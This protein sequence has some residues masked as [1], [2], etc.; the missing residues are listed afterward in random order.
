MN[1]AG[2]TR[3]RD[4]VFSGTDNK[5]RE[6]SVSERY[7]EQQVQTRGME[8]VSIASSGK[9]PVH[10]Y[11]MQFGTQQGMHVQGYSWIL[12]IID[13]HYSPYQWLHSIL[14]HIPGIIPF[15]RTPNSLHSNRCIFAKNLWTTLHYRPFHSIRAH[16]RF[17]ASL[18]R[19]GQCRSMTFFS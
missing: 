16:V 19:I 15:G 5:H 17:N 10:T 4:T 11:A 8:C 18:T 6:D 14:E 7:A 1:S 12:S 13:L 9:Q 3:V 2:F